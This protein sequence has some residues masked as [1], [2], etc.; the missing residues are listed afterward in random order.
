MIEPVATAT[1]LPTSLNAAISNVAGM[2]FEDMHLLR[3]VKTN[4]VNSTRL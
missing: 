1:S 2:T 4:I 3:S